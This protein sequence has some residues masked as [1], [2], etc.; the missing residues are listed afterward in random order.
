MMMYNSLGDDTESERSRIG[1]LGW[2]LFHSHDL[3]YRDCENNTM[4]F[5]PGIRHLNDSIC[6]TVR[7][8]LDH[9]MD[10]FWSTH[11]WTMI[12]CCHKPAYNVFRLIRHTDE[13][14][15]TIH[16]V[17]FRISSKIYT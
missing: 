8:S 16:A 15:C 17:R 5:L 11:S 4:E 1:E 14:S 10:A 9:S 7:L 13:D 12:R 6:L 2:T 3:L